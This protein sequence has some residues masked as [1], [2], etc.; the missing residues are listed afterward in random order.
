MAFKSSKWPAPSTPA[1]DD[2]LGFLQQVRLQAG[3]VDV[4]ALPFALIYT[5]DL[6]QIQ[7]FPDLFPEMECELEQL[8]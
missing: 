1:G 5:C 6:A 8:V 4:R 7:I 3:Q 2:P